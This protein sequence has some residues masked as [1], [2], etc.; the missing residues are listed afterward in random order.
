MPHRHLV[1]GPLDAWWVVRLH[2]TLGPGVVCGLA[3]SLLPWP[4]TGYDKT[5]DRLRL[6]G[7]VYVVL[8]DRVFAT[9]A[10]VTSSDAPTDEP[11]PGSGGPGDTRGRT[12]GA[13]A[14]SGGATAA[15]TTRETPPA[16]KQRRPR[17]VANVLDVGTPFVTA[18]VDELGRMIDRHVE[19]THAVDMHATPCPT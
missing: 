14:G 5:R 7:Q 16:R 17:H 10:R 12:A 11:T 18:A 13:G 15:T 2:M 8:V 4:R 6:L 3:G 1:N 9:A 19:V